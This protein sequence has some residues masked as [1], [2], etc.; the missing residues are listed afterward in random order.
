M[1]VFIGHP[2]F[3]AMGAKTGYSLLSGLSFIV[4]CFSGLGAVFLKAVPVEALNAILMFVGLAICCDALDVTPQRH[5][6]VFIVSM[7]PA[8]CNWAIKLCAIFAETMCGG[9]GKCVANP[10]T[11]GAFAMQEGL[12]GIYSLGQGY[13]VTCIYFTCMLIYVVDREFL[14]AALWAFISA[15]SAMFGLIH[16]EVVFVPWSIPAGHP[17][18]LIW[19]FVGTY[20]AMGLIF[21]TCAVLQRFGL[22]EQ[23]LANTA[24]KD[25]AKD[26]AAAKDGVTMEAAEAG[27]LPVLLGRH[28]ATEDGVKK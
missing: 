7:V 24:C 9:M 1:T 17:A 16:S 18:S 25:A 22:V 14:K 6:P 15:L 23:P 10:Y 11:I 4:V 2:A 28:N 3:K 8:M 12:L 26:E 20:A 27:H 19:R 5:W 13:I 21:L